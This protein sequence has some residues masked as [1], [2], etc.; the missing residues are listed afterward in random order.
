M[1][2]R[3]FFLLL[4]LFLPIPVA[5]FSLKW[6]HDAVITMSALLLICYMGSCIFYDRFVADFKWSWFI[7]AETD[8]LVSQ[9]CQGISLASYSFIFLE[10]PKIPYKS[11]KPISQ[12]Q[13]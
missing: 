12:K 9:L 7:G 3:V 6:T 1:S 5:H 13:T 2:K 8:H 4:L 10:K 11:K